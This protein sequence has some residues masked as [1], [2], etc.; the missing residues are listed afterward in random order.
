MHPVGQ[1][2]PNDLG[3]FDI[4]GNAVEWCG[5]TYLPYPVTADE[6]PALD[7]FV[8]TEIT[9]STPRTMRGDVFFFPLPMVRSALRIT[10]RPSTRATVV[11]F[12]P[13]RT[14]P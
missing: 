14:L 8:A 2:K 13:A 5:D 4:L 10:E 11:G 3:I 1:K 12:R 9:D 6:R 7:L